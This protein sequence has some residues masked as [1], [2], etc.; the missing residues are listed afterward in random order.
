MSYEGYQ[1]VLCTHGHDA[2]IDAY[3]VAEDWRCPVCEAPAAYVR[4]VDQTNGDDPADPRTHPGPLTLI[5]EAEYC[6]CRC[7]H[8][9]RTKAA[10][11]APAGEGWHPVT[12]RGD[13]PSCP[14]G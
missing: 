12:G 3:D 8:M 2:A 11:W 1:E 14:S 10:R 6:T 5:A 4:D 9:H 13:D 7:G